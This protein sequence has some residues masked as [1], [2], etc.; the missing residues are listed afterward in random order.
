M[1]VH[2]FDTYRWHRFEGFFE[3]QGVPCRRL[4]EQHESTLLLKQRN[5]CS[6]LISETGA[7]GSSD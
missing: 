5:I 4:L 2:Y 7:S 3:S 1:V 6:Q